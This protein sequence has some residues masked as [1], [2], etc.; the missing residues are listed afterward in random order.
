MRRMHWE[1]I[2]ERLHK[3]HA[4]ETEARRIFRDL[5]AH[6]ELP[7]V[8][9]RVARVQ[10]HHDVEWTARCAVMAIES[11]IKYE[12]RFIRWAINGAPKSRKMPQKTKATVEAILNKYAFG[13]ANTKVHNG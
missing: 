4:T 2:A 8:R 13:H 12:A 6:F 1:E 10:T 9:A 5:Y 7:H 3:W 11:K